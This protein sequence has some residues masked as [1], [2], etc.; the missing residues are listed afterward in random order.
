MSFTPAGAASAYN[1]PIYLPG[2]GP[3]SFDQSLRG[4]NGMQTQTV[5]AQT[6]GDVGGSV[7]PLVVPPAVTFSV[8]DPEAG[9]EV[10]VLQE[11][12]PWPLQYYRSSE[13]GF[14]TDEE[15][16][17]QYAATPA[18]DPKAFGTRAAAPEC[19]DQDLQP[20]QQIIV[21]DSTRRDYLE[22]QRDVLEGIERTPANYIEREARDQQSEALS[23]LIF[24]EVDYA[25]MG[26]AVPDFDAVAANIRVRAPDDPVFQRA[27]DR[28]EARLEAK[29]KSEGRTPDQLGEVIKAGEA[30]DFDK[31]RSLTKDQF[32]AMADGLGP[33]ASP[34]E[35]QAEIVRRTAIYTTYLTREEAYSQAIFDGVGDANTEIMVT[36]PVN[37]VL[38]IAKAGGEGWADKSIAKL[39]ELVASREYTPN[40]VIAIMSDPEIQKLVR[41]GLRNAETFDS[42]E[43]GNLPTLEGQEDFDRFQDIIEIYSTV[44]YADGDP[45]VGTGHG[46]KLV[47]DMAQFMIDNSIAEDNSPFLGQGYGFAFQ[48]SA[49]DGHLALALAVGAKAQGVENSAFGGLN[50][51]EA[52]A[53]MGFADFR[54]SYDALQERITEESAFLGI[55]LA[56]IGGDSVSTEKRL[57]IINGMIDAYPEE[58][59][60]LNGSL[61]DLNTLVEQREAAQF[62]VDGYASAYDNGDFEVIIRDL[63]KIP[64]FDPVTAS[65]STG[66]PGDPSLQ[67]TLP[68]WFMR[69]L[70][71]MSDH[72]I[73]TFIPS[74]GGTDAFQRGSKGLS[75]FLF[76]SNAAALVNGPVEDF[77]YVPLHSMMAATHGLTALLGKEWSKHYFGVTPGNQANTPFTRTANGYE[78]NVGQLLDS[79]EGRFS[80]LHISPGVRKTLVTL[81]KGAIRDPLDIG[82]IAVD[83]YNAGANFLGKT[84]TE[85]QDLVKGFAY[86]TIVGSDVAL[87]IGAGVAAAGTGATFAGL[88][89]AAWTGIGFGLMVLGAG[90][91]F[92]KGMHDNAHAYDAHNAKAWE[93]LGIKDPEVARSLGIG[94]TFSDGDAFKNAGPFLVSMFANA[95]YTPE[96]MTAWINENWTA[97]QADH[98]ATHVKGNTRQSDG[99]YP[100]VS[101]ASVESYAE[102]VGI[103]IPDHYNESNSPFTEFN[104]DPWADLP[105]YNPD[106]PYNRP[107]G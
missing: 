69:A 3:A 31:V 40:Q 66:V 76:A 57:D 82:Y 60:K 16:F 84:E 46:R 28:A 88:S 7:P 52:F 35:I 64:K 1:V 22:Q 92:F 11:D 85:E 30:G 26:Q 104:P 17:A 80:G 43:Q 103:P 73:T 2:T 13:F 95:G 93:L 67:P 106:D 9:I 97:E 33:D 29:W 42:P 100:E 90:A 8:D 19:A 37:S 101:F 68:L 44:L 55:P 74:V 25:T 65:S 49:A 32:I 96:Q 18:L 24:S 77:I 4:A 21:L 53:A 94:G 34:V 12:G 63:G 70:R 45:A 58:V 38:D 105:P 23:D 99:S 51:P 98:I 59:A 89:A 75:A 72:M 61:K 14:E 10:H 27:I 102:Y 5:A 47:D 91:I 50:Q 81:G 48:S 15:L 41:Q 79:I 86:A 62:A 83:G 36:R 87:I 71:G 20:G 78:V 6:P 54:E 107:Y 39:R 56:S